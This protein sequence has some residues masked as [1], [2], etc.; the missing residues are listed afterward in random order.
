[1]LLIEEIEEIDEIEEMEEIDEID[2]ML[3]LVD[4]DA[5]LGCATA[6]VQAGMPAVASAWA[7]RSTWLAS[8]PG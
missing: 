6:V 7:N 3:E 2:E 4:M 8:R 1:M 5:P